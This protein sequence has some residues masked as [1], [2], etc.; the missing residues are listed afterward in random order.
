LCFHVRYQPSESIALMKD[1]K[2]QANEN[3]GN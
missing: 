3:A 1:K 2:N